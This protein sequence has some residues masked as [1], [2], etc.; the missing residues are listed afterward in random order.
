MLSICGNTGTFGGL[1]K[2]SYYA[3]EIMWKL[4]S[5]GKYK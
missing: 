2:S 4:I 5:K 3:M 1:K